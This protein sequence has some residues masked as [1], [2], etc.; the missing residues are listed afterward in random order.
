MVATGFDA[1][2]LAL[3]RR[4]PGVSELEKG[5]LVEVAIREGNRK[6]YAALARYVGRLDGAYGRRDRRMAI[7]GVWL[8]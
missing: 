5:L 3:R 7:R 1:R 4:A 6:L 2:P 8:W